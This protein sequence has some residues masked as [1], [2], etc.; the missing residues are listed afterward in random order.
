MV[1]IAFNQMN[2]TPKLYAAETLNKAKMYTDVLVHCETPAKYWEH[3][4]YPSVGNWL[5]KLKVYP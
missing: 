5:R 1:F 2:F 3:P 4:K